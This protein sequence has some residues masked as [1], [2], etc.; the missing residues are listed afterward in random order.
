MQD[1]KLML[2]AGEKLTKFQRVYGEKQLQSDLKANVTVKNF[3][4]FFDDYSEKFE[5]IH[6]FLTLY[7]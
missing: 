7:V 6:D 1:K 2:L 3:R 5:I 4:T